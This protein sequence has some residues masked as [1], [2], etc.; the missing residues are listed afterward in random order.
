MRLVQASILTAVA[1]SQVPCRR[2]A[3]ELKKRRKEVEALLGPMMEIYS[4][5]WEVSRPQQA[6]L[7]QQF[8]SRCC[9]NMQKCLACQT[10]ASRALETHCSGAYQVL[11]LS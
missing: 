11:G 2:H 5:P 8:E 7:R 10:T 3:Q 4:D 1:C 9:R 6:F